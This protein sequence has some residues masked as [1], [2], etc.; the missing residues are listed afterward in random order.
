M[1]FVFVNVFFYLS[2]HQLEENPLR[3][4]KA[5]PITIGAECDACESV[6]VFRHPLLSEWVIGD[7]CYCQ[8]LYVM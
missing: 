5:Q 7:I 1:S 8:P 6:C 2:E 4:R 3:M